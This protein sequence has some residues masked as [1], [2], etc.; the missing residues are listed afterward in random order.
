MKLRHFLELCDDYYDDMA[1][2]LAKSLT[3]NRYRPQEG[4]L[5]FAKFITFLVES[6]CSRNVN[7]PIEKSDYWFFALDAHKDN[8]LDG[9]ELDT[10]LGVGQLQPLFKA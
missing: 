9:I 10:T 3:S 7:F 8:E 2:N 4:I 1:E 6:L 5:T